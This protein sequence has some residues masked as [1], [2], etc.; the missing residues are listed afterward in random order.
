MAHFMLRKDFRVRRVQRKECVGSTPGCLGAFMSV[1]QNVHSMISQLIANA[2]LYTAPQ[3]IAYSK[4]KMLTL[5]LSTT[6]KPVN[7]AICAQ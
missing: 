7:R 2:D 1:S 6:V 5:K 3:L 4:G